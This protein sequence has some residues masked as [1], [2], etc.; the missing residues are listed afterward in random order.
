MTAWALYLLAVTVLL[1]VAA[2]AGE[3]ALA[4]YGRQVRWVWALALAGGL[5]LPL[6]VQPGAEVVSEAA[7]SPEL[8]EQLAVATPAAAA[9]PSLLDRLRA[10]EALDRAFGWFWAGSAGLALLGLAMATRRLISASEGLARSSTRSAA[11]TSGPRPACARAG[12]RRCRAKRIRSSTEA[13]RPSAA[14]EARPKLHAMR[15]GRP[16]NPTC[17][18]ASCSRSRRATASSCGAAIPGAS[19]TNVSAA[20]RPTASL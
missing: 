15:R 10:P 6:V 11:S 16:R 4:L 12:A 3:S 17:A 14:A 9:E 2:R 8:L 18:A 7:V 20:V 5:T 1:G 13:A 19:T